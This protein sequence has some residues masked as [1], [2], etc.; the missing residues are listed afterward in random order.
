MTTNDDADLARFVRGVFE[1][2][3]E[4]KRASAE[5]L[6][7]TVV[8]AARVLASGLAAGGTL[9]TF[10]NGGSAADAQHLAGEL[11]GR[12]HRTRKPL[13]AVALS[14]DPSTVTCIANDFAYDE[15]FARQLAGLLRPNDVA[16]GIST[17]GRSPNVLAGLAK[18]RELGAKTVALTGG[19][20]GALQGAADVVVVAPARYTPRIQE[21]H[22][23]A[24]HAISELLELLLL[25]MPLPTDVGP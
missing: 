21:C 7:D 4:A 3:A 24:I 1:A 18:A 10:G 11:M 17:S 6:P 8:A 19:D 2:S 23:A 9:Y 20:A 16:L 5:Q 25:D 13:A 22:L 15:I 12:Y 14:T